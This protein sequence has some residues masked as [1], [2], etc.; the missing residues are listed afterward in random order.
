MSRVAWALIEKAITLG[1]DAAIALDRFLDARR[2]R[3]KKGLSFKDVAHQ[4]EQIASATRAR[5]PTVVIR[6]R[7]PP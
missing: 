5:A 7:P 4:Q 6:R 2:A 1:F 3:K